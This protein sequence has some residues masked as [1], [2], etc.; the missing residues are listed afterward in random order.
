MV[1]NGSRSVVAID[2]TMNQCE[3]DEQNNLDSVN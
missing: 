1:S 3:F 2:P